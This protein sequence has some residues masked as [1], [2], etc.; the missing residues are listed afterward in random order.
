MLDTWEQTLVDGVIERV[1]REGGDGRT[2]LRRLF[3]AAGAA[4]DLL[5]VELAVRDWARRDP[6]VAERRA[7]GSTTGGWTTCA[8]CSPSSATTRPR[9]RRAACSSSPCSSGESYVAADHGRRSRP[10]VVAAAVRHL[11]RTPQATTT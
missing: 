7:R 1:D 10:S 3:A 2:R 5:A 9:S 11:V 4:A 6:A 8:R